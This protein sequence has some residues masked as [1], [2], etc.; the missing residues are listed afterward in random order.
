MSTLPHCH[1]KGKL[2]SQFTIEARE[3]PRKLLPFTDTQDFEEAKHGFIAAPSYRRIMNDKG[4]VAWNME[5][6]DFLLIEAQRSAGVFPCIRT[7]DS[8]R[9]SP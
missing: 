1:L 5:N 3:Q 2:P 8:S 4:D 9:S 6:W 7:E